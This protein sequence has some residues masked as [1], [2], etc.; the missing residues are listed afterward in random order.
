M[1]LIVDALDAHHQ[2]SI[3]LGDRG[4]PG[5]TEAEPKVAHQDFYK[6]LA[7]CLISSQQLLIVPTLERFDSR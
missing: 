6:S 4:K 1:G 3:D 5:A 2:R 7:N